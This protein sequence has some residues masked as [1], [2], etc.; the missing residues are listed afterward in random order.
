MIQ[1]AIY[2]FSLS[3]WV[4]Q[5]GEDLVGCVQ[6]NHPL[7]VSGMVSGAGDQSLLICVSMSM[8][9]WLNGHMAQCVHSASTTQ[10]C[11]KGTTH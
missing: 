11:A 1:A 4:Q 5:T 3:L 8:M 9:C 7:R 6:A 2:I 10:L